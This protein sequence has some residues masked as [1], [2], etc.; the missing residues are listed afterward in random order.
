[1]A[2]EVLGRKT[3]GRRA[4]K[5]NIFP[6]RYIH[7]PPSMKTVFLK[8]FNIQEQPQLTSSAILILVYN[9]ANLTLQSFTRTGRKITS[10]MW[11][12]YTAIM[13]AEKA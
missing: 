1:M 4:V 13:M 2:E 3:A 11:V 5:W 8:R 7:F 12:W 10:K 9:T 6:A